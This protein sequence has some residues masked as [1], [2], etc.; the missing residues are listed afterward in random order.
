MNDFH[1]FFV[2]NELI[3]ESHK[4]DRFYERVLNGKIFDFER[5]VKLITSVRRQPIIESATVKMSGF[6]NDNRKT[7]PLN[8]FNPFLEMSILGTSN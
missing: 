6:S 8:E 2:L 7:L 3:I 4:I 5:L 1:R